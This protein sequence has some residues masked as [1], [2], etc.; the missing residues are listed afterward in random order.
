MVVVRG[1]GGHG[2]WVSVSKMEDRL[3]FVDLVL[4]LL[5][6]CWA[7]GIL[8]CW[9]FS[10]SF[11]RVVAV[12]RC[13]CEWGFFFLRFFRFL[14]PHGGAGGEGGSEQNATDSVVLRA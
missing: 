3:R 5:G 8:C 6:L 12:C 1:R 9:C 14:A 13:V 2:C 7:V 10:V 11:G 4:Q